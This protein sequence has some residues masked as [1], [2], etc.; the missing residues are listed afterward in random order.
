MIPTPSG[1]R[2]SP[3]DRGSRPHRAMTRIKNVPS[4][5]IA[6]GDATFPPVGG[7]LW[8]CVLQ[9]SPPRGEAVER[10]ETDEGALFSG[11]MWPPGGISISLSP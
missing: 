9:A 7:R 3:P 6:Y 4:S 8:G 11:T 1:L 10:S 5:V 2:P